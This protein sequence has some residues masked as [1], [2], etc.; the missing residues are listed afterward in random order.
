[1]NKIKIIRI[2]MQH[3]PPA[4]NGNYNLYNDIYLYK[5]LLF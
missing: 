5:H 1:M 2:K 4:F 3:I